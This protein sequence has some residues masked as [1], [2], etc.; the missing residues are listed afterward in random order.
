MDG[1]KRMNRDE[2]SV[3]H[4]LDDK[5]IEVNK[6]LNELAD[7]H[8]EI[9]IITETNYINGRQFKQVL[10]EFITRKIIGKSYVKGV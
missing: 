2:R 8:L 9:D 1:K 6:L 4:E 10:A 5:L 3:I 7:S